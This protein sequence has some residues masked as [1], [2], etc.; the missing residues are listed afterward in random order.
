MVSKKDSA[1]VLAIKNFFHDVFRMMRWFAVFF[2]ATILF[3]GA[4]ILTMPFHHIGL[5]PFAEFGTW[6]IQ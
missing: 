3:F 2:I 4:W 1:L 6:F 5:G